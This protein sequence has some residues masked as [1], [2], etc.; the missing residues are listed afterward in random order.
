MQRDTTIA[1]ADWQFLLTQLSPVGPSSEY[2][3]DGR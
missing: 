2:G 1:Q 3:Q